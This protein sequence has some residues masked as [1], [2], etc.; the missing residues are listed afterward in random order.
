MHTLGEHL[1]VMLANPL[2]AN[3]PTNQKQKNDRMDAKNL[4]G[5]CG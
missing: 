4:R 1:D 2:K 5:F 3:R